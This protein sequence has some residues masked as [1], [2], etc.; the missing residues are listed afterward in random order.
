ME[1]KLRFAQS[2]SNMD[3]VFYMRN[4]EL[5]LNLDNESWKKN[6]LA[7]VNFGTNFLIGWSKNIIL[8]EHSQSLQFYLAAIKDINLNL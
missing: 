4:N 7:L 8:R 6:V 3:V 1:N 2:K 5:G